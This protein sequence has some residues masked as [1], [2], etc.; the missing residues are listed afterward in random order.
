MVERGTS[1]LCVLGRPY[2]RTCSAAESP[3]V[4]QG[5]I[6][7]QEVNRLCAI[8]A[9]GVVSRIRSLK[10]SPF[11]LMRRVSETSFRLQEWSS[12]FDVV[13]FVQNDH[14]RSFVWFGNQ[15]IAV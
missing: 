11:H 4:E 9:D 14:A 12:F 2:N 13:G 8:T 5:R 10:C 7:L 3:A 15:N 1:V 6:N